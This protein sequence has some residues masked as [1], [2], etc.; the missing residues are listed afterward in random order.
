[1]RFKVSGSGSFID[2][3]SI[4][5]DVS[6]PEEL[7]KRVKTDRA[8]LSIRQSYQTGDNTTIYKLVDLKGK[9]LFEYRI[10]RI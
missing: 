3:S 5:Y 6:S 8:P 7:H 2:Y 4:E 9:S 10:E 1:M